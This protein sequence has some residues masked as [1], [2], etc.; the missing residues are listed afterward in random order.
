MDVP[1]T[2]NVIIGGQP[3]TM[4]RL[5]QHLVSFRYSV[6]QM[7]RVWASSSVISNDLRML[8]S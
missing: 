1:T 7:T 8:F 3:F 4:L 2:Y 6:R 5:S